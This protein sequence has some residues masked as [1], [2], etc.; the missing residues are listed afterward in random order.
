LAKEQAAKDAADAAAK[1]KADREAADK[2]AKESAAAQKAAEKAAQEDAARRAKEAEEAQKAAEKAAKDEA[3]RQ[4]QELAAAQQ[5]EKDRLAKEQAA[6][7]KARLEQ[8]AIDAANAKRLAEA[9]K[10]PAEAPATQGQPTTHQRPAQTHELTP[11]AKKAFKQ[12]LTGIQFEFNS[13]VLTGSSDAVLNN[14]VKVMNDNPT[15]NLNIAGHTDN[16]GTDDYNMTLSEKRAQ[17][18]K[19][20]LINKGGIS[21]SR[22]QS[23]GFGATLPLD[24]NNTAQGRATNRRVDLTVYFEE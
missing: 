12:A 19:E 8:E 21:A 14:V 13:A 11:E 9:A 23:R 6:A 18:V 20:Y 5:A 10:K 22:L 4:A 1:A 2:L 15:Y 16:V 7:E 24:T 3:A 17:A